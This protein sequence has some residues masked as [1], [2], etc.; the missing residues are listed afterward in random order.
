MKDKGKNKI[1]GIGAPKTGTTSL[2]KA[3]EI[4]NFKHM[5]FDVELNRKY[6]EG[7]YE[8][9]FRLAENYDSFEDGPWNRGEFYKELDRQFQNSKFILTVRE[10]S[11]W[12]ESYEKHFSAK[13][14]RENPQQLWIRK[15][16]R[17]RKNELMSWYEERTKGVLEYF[18]DK[19]EDLLIMNICNGEGW[20]KLCPFLDIDIPNQPFP[21]QNITENRDLSTLGVWKI[22]VTRF[23]RRR[24]QTFEQTLHKLIR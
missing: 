10:L 4:L 21:R 8:A 5:S 17:Q 23:G 15:Y 1:F 7:D 16:D 22:I 18:K 12:I 3:L 9:I 20:E 6:E 19:R 24:R 11:S 2:G 13:Q 14:L